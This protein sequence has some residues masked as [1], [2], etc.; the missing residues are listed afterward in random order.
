VQE[1]RENDKYEL[2]SRTIIFHPSKH[3]TIHE[4]NYIHEESKYEKKQT[5]VYWEVFPQQI[6]LPPFQM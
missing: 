3:H 1:K 6:A 2:F 4:F 5:F